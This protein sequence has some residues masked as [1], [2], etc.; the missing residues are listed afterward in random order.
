MRSSQGI[1]A[2]WLGVFAGI[3]A[4]GD[5]AVIGDDAAIAA[6]DAD[7]AD[8]GD[9]WGLEGAAD[10]VGDVAGT[11]CLTD[12][13]CVDQ[14][15]EK[16]PCLVAQCS[17]GYC[18]QI[19]KPEGT[20][21]KDSA[22]TP[23]ACSQTTCSA[24][25]C[26]L[27]NLKDGAACG[28]GACGQK[29]AA[30]SCIAA[31]DADYDDGNP[32]TK[33]YC[34]QGIAI[35]HDPITD[36]TLPCDDADACTSGDTCIGGTCKG[37]PV[38]CSDGIACTLDTCS[39]AKGCAHT[40]Q[41]GKCDDGNPCTVDGCDL[42]LGCTVTSLAL[43]VTCSDGNECTIADACDATGSCTG[44]VS[45]ACACSTDADCLG[46]TQNL[47]IGALVC[48]NASCV[49]VGAN[50]VYCDSS[51]DSVCLHN[52]CDPASG[53][54][55]QK[56]KNEGAPC[57]D[58]NDCTTGETCQT[59]A[60]VGTGLLACDDKNPCTNDVCVPQSGCVHEVN[61][62]PCDDANACTTGDV[63]AKGACGGAAKPC[64][65]AIACTLDSCVKASGTCVHAPDVSTCDDGNP[66]TT[67][68][69]APQKGC[70]Y[71]NNDAASCDDGNACTANS[72]Q[73][74]TC[75]ATPI[76]SC[77]TDGDCDDKNP[78]T[79]DSCQASKCQFKPQDGG[80]CDAADK[81]QT[82]GSGTCGG[83]VCKAGNSPKDCSSLSDACH[84]GACAPGTGQC[85]A[86]SK[87]DGTPCDADQDG[88]T[89]GDACAVG[90]CTPGKPFDCGQ[91]EAG[92]ACDFGVCVN[93]GGVPSCSVQHKSGGTACTDGQYCT[94]GD[95]CD[96]NGQC[97]GGGPRSCGALADACNSGACNETQ[98]ACV[99]APKIA[100]ISCDDGQFCTTLDQ[101]DGNGK[102]VGLGVTACA[103]TACAAGSCDPANQACALT[104]VPATTAC[105]D[106]N[107]CTIND[108]CDASGDCQPGQGI[109]C[110][111]QACS[112]GWC[113]PTTGG[114]VQKPLDVTATCD[115]G[116][117]CT[118]GDHCDGFGACAG[119]AWNATCGCNADAMCNDGNPCTVDACDVATA[120][121][122]F[123][124]AAGLPCDDGAPCTT[125]SACTP[126]GICVA[127][128]LFDCSASSDTCH[129]GQCVASGSTPVC[130]AVALG[131]GT[132]CN[133]GLF[134]TAGETCT[135]GTCGGGSPVICAPAPACYTSA[136]AESTQ[137]CANTPSTQGTACSDNEPCTLGDACDGLGG[138]QGGSAMANFAA[139]DDGDGA[140]SGDVC[141]SAKCAG[142]GIVADASGPITRVTYDSTGDSW[143]F[144]GAQTTASSVALA[145]K[146]SI[147]EIAITGGGGWSLAQLAASQNSGPIRAL[148]P[149]VAGGANNFTAFHVPG[150]KSWVAG[151]SAA[152]GKAVSAPFLAT[153]EW[154]S[155]AF[156]VAGTSGYA[157]LA[158]H[159]ATD[160]A[161][162]GR[163]QGGP[164]DTTTAWT[165]NKGAVSGAFGTGTAISAYTSIC[166]PAGSCAPPLTFIGG[167]QKWN[168][169][170]ANAL[171]TVSAAGISGTW[172]AVSTGPNLKIA[173]SLATGGL[174]A[175]NTA[176]FM[177]AGSSLVWTVGPSGSIAYV[178]DGS[179]VLTG[180]S[181][182]GSNYQFSDVTAVSGSVLV[183]GHKTDPATG[184]L[185]PVLLTHADTAYGQADATTWVEHDLALPPYL[186]AA[187]INSGF[188]SYGM[189]IGGKTGQT[190]ALAGNY[191]GNTA[192]VNPANLR[193]MLY[194]RH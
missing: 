145:S 46:K 91:V 37:A 58:G 77:A 163:C 54:C 32:C 97:V 104:P 125:A 99:T 39:S 93:T 84:T 160:G 31:T 122:T 156:R 127:T 60:C 55:A 3:S 49:A 187:C 7:A 161:V 41:A 126:D 21:C 64:D 96:G 43:G 186:P 139:C 67:D 143:W 63:C 149:Q 100:G 171:D 59:G 94:V 65:D 121:C 101:C 177:T 52:G 172:G 107:P 69:C 57:D 124:L 44:Q 95:G 151:T 61:T 38:S 25:Q 119:G 108:Q 102:C 191:C 71:A 79:A 45:G 23:G 193:G 137:G 141:L 181:L 115:D 155:A 27:G 16:S 50:A 183:W 144:S 81:C 1:L 9:V 168:G 140:T 109:V 120:A 130:Q 184:N 11:D 17:N 146:W 10:T 117:S 56:S 5:I 83:G 148:S 42:A 105:N 188:A 159:N 147:N 166:F 136:C 133:D 15:K 123:Q 116:Q 14:F 165:C 82:S 170:V 80:A 87:G 189:A 174:L 162:L 154:H 70:V 113:D 47:C 128:A 13:D 110:P 85:S 4:C 176:Q 178:A 19:A 86:L 66:C 150:S 12:F 75:T 157:L 180:V 185:V 53:K 68:S 48:Q 29:C 98:Q 129:V 106:G 36:L 134:C 51:Q 167:L 173:S 20:T 131:D 192:Y 35:K 18:A 73:G 28:A 194:V 76:C 26:V 33:D 153:T 132:L 111:G 8:A 169:S 88:C 30:G 34:D 72:C 112:A 190:I 142:F 152:F 89:V 22:V 90:V 6:P 62:G 164:G 179:S 182:Y 2:A 92:N 175:Y 138:C 158:G 103:G 135:A 118:V 24:G 114:C 40:A 74:G 78:C